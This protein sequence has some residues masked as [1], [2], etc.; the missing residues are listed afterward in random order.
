MA[1]KPSASGRESQGTARGLTAHGLTAHGATVPEG[2][3]RGAALR[4]NPLAQWHLTDSDRA[5]I[6]H[7]QEDGRRPFVAIARDVG[8]SEKTV[9]ARVHQLIEANVIQIVALASPTALGYNAGALLGITTD[10]AAPSSRIAR[11][12]TDIHDIDYV[13]LT[14]GRYGIFAEIIA[15]D[16][17]AMQR[18]IE[19]DVGAIDGIRSVEVFPYASVYYQKAK[20]FSRDD[21]DAPGGVKQKKLDLADREIILELSRDGRAPLNTIAAKLG[22]SETMVRTRIAALLGSGQMSILALLNPMNLADR[23]LAWLGIRLDPAADPHVAAEAI[24]AVKNVSYIA[25][26]SGR[27]DLFVE[28]VCPSHEDIVVTA[29][30]QIG[31]I[32]EVTHLE[33]FLYV[34]LHYKSLVPTGR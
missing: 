9:R 23:T 32:A 25:I 14:T 34:D 18:V 15:E 24:S 26:C 19:Q 12:L 28:L 29:R 4:R 6:A 13:A 17:P 10:P 22:V 8:L 31:R 16:F 20:F 30:R 1:K 33:A 21:N 5:I 2:A 27:Y 3:S 11:A 7:L